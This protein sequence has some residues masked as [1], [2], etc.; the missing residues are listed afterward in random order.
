ML[1]FFVFTVTQRIE[2][3]DKSDLIAVKAPVRL[4]SQICDNALLAALQHVSGR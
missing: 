3:G 4:R 1:H 2:G